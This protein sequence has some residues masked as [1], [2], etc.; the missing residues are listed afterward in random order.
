MQQKPNFKR[1]T[2]MQQITDGYGPVFTMIVIDNMHQLQDIDTI[3]LYYGT[4]HIYNSIIS[5]LPKSMY[6]SHSIELYSVDTTNSNSLIHV[7][8]NDISITQFIFSTVG[9][10]ESD[11]AKLKYTQ[12][13]NVF[14]DH[15]EFQSIN[16]SSKY[17]NGFIEINSPYSIHLTRNIFGNEIYKS[18][19]P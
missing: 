10:M 8:S 13:R 15:H 18:D 12:K 2:S 6:T 1:K 5:Y 9:K 11:A 4:L 16:S 19:I 7:S 17:S 14:M 3:Q